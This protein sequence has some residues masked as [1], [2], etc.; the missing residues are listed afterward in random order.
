MARGSRKAGEVQGVG[1]DVRADIED[2][3]ARP[4]VLLEAA[5][6]VRLEGAGEVDREVDA[7][8]QVEPP[9]HPASPDFHEILPAEGPAESGRRKVE[10]ARDAQFGDG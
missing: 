4:D 6:G 1:A 5:Q 9:P 3:G 10:K 2:G 7:F 8:T